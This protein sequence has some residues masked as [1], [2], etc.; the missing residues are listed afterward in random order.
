LLSAYAAQSLVHWQRSLLAMF[1]DWQWQVLSLP[2]RH[3]SWRV[4]GN[5]LYWSVT[6]RG[7]LERD[8]DLL[9]ATSMVDLATLRGLVPALARVPNLLY[10]HEN[11]FDY[12]RQP[13]QS[14]LLEAQ[15]VSLYSALAADQLLFNS[16][17]NRATFLDGLASL[18]DRLPDRVPAG[19]VASLRGKARVLPVAIDPEPRARGIARWPGT[20][21]ERSARPL[22]LLWVGRFEHD[23][24]GDRLLL[25]L[26]EL[27]RQ[28]LDYELAM[29]GQQFR[30]SPAVFGE[31][32]ARFSHRLVHFGYLP[33]VADYRA[34]LHA[35]DVVLTT[36]LHEFQGLAV[37]E[38]VASGCLPAVPDRLSYPELYP[39]R[40]RY[41]SRLEDAAGEA[42][43]A[44]RLI[45]ELAPQDET[46][47]P[48]V[49][50]FA[51]ARLEP[52]Y[53]SLLLG[54]GRGAKLSEGR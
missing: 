45:C 3:F 5:P 24:G 7:L 49:S 54:R 37:L 31:I 1:P 34:L 42:R 9:L 30:C 25:I 13:G 39:A 20:G 33:S 50:A 18:L 22:R 26:R 8:Y 19:V 15:M 21:G 4:R 53:R 47:A 17:Y 38:A 14:S 10:F 36:A 32:E 44:A 40:F 43:G 23:K 48:D 52:R 16:A 35:A 2:P 41:P 27:D 28:G 11:Q 6:E 29:C 51:L 46:V 12:P